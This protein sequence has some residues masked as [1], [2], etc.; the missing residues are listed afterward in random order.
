MS[1]STPKAANST[2]IHKSLCVDTKM[3]FVLIRSIWA[4]MRHVSGKSAPH[5]G[6]PEWP[7]HDQT[8]SDQIKHLWSPGFAHYNTFGLASE[9]IGCHIF[10]F[11]TN[12]S[13]VTVK[14]ICINTE[15]R[16]LQLSACVLL[17]KNM[18]LNF[19]TSFY[20]NQI[21]SQIKRSN[22]ANYNMKSQPESSWNPQTVQSLAT[23]NEICGGHTTSSPSL[24]Y[25]TMPYSRCNISDYLF[26]VLIEMCPIHSHPMS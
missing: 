7:Q 1:C 21:W 8:W 9:Y 20:Q 18:I 12:Q 5:E 6:W 19:T 26:I 24:Q 10:W 11:D 3:Y 2:R 4:T 22:N 17:N 23:R 14:M 25:T 13:D 16:N 15:K